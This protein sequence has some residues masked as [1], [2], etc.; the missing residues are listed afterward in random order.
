MLLLRIIIKPY[1]KLRMSN[2]FTSGISS[3][4]NSSLNNQNPKFHTRLIISKYWRWQH[5][6]KTYFFF[7]DSIASRAS[8]FSSS[9]W[10]LAMLSSKFSSYLGRSSF[11][12][13][14]LLFRLIRWKTCHFISFN[15]LWSN[16]IALWVVE[17]CDINALFV[18]FFEF[19]NQKIH[20]FLVA[21]Q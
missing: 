20:S 13:P 8:L 6:K 15:I 4:L 2:D 14:S 12:I 19:C 11:L 17:E 7:W 3:S 9:N 16:G 18:A 5:K 1:I 10:A 21:S